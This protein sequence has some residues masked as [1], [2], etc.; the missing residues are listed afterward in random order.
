[1]NKP[2]TVSREATPKEL[3][4]FLKD[5]FDG[6]NYNGAYITSDNIQAAM[7]RRQAR[8][9]IKEGHGTAADH[10]LIAGADQMV[11]N[12]LVEDEDDA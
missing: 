8:R 2:K 5:Q 7:M 9:R 10:E 12:I 4:N 11:T 1:M 3:K 6:R